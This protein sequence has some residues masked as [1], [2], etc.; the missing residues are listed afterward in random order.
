MP[1]PD[2]LFPLCAT[3]PA[4]LTGVSLGIQSVRPPED[5]LSPSSPVLHTAHIMRCIKY[6]LVFVRLGLHFLHLKT[7]KNKNGGD[8]SVFLSPRVCVL[9]AELTAW[10]S[11]KSHVHPSPPLRPPHLAWFFFPNVFVFTQSVI[12]LGMQKHGSVR[13]CTSTHSDTCAHLF[14]LVLM[15]VGAHTLPRNTCVLALCI[16][17]DT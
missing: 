1:H 12:R 3:V 10:P 17:D 9:R 4:P 2:A 5:A 13:A 11:C 15:H 6:L 16:L 8:R 7:I 14:R